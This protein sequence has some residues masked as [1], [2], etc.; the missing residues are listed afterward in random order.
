[1]ARLSD[2]EHLRRLRLERDLSYRALAEEVGVSAMALYN[3]LLDVSHPTERTLY[4]IHE[5]LR[6]Q[7]VVA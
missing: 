6:R 5:Y 1:M 2:I 4:K 7:R 3:V